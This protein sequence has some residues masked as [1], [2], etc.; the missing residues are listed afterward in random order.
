MIRSSKTLS[1]SGI[2]ALMLTSGLA[3][4]QDQPP[5]PP[6]TA[7]PANGGW[8]RAGQAP[9]DQAPPTA[10]PPQTDPT[11][12][13]DRSDAYGQPAQTMPPQT[14]QEETMP[15]T[16][17]PQSIRPQSMPQST[18]RPAYGIPPDLIIKPG[19]FFTVRINQMLASNRNKP[20]DLFTAT[21]TQPLVAN[22]I[23]V[24]QRG[25]TVAGTVADTGKDKDGK[26]FIRLQLTAI[27]A[28]DGSQIPIKSQ[29]SSMQGRSTP[30]GIEAGTVVATT[31][32]GAAVGGAAA[33]GT[34]AA[35][36]AGAGALVGLAAVFATHNHPAVIYPETAFTFQ[37]TAPATVATGNAP[38]AFRY[39]GQQ[40][41][42]PQPAMMQGGPRPYPGA[43]YAYPGATYA[44]PAPYAYPPAYYYGP[45]YYPGY[46]PYYWGPSIGIGFGFRGYGGFG[47]GF[48]R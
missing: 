43:S 10:L 22:G 13:V 16:M 41:Y 30:G 34:G 25:Q 32:V 36:G 19:T 17:P 31:A 29:L 28:A 5:A 4:A 45:G 3:L 23:V 11:Q 48:R 27:T 46:Y 2:T 37:I 33:W 39:A 40:D 20:G 7:P 15:Q 38:Q 26:H 44:Y 21:L 1:L 9:P 18:M 35:I 42:Q 24:A 8:R 47:R 12:P 14:T 6:N